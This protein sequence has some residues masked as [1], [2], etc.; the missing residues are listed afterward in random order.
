MEHVR[1][2]PHPVERVWRAI[3]EPGPVAAWFGPVDFDLRVGGN[4]RFGPADAPW[5]TSAITRLEPPTLIEFAGAK[6]TPSAGFIR[7]ELTPVDDGCRMVFTQRFEPQ[8]HFEAVLGD[9]GGDLP[10]G[11]G[12]PW[13]PGFVGG[14]HDFLDRLGRTL[15]GAAVT[16]PST[17]LF[18]RLADHAID[19]MVAERNMSAELATQTMEMFHSAER[20]NELNEIYR[21]HI[22]IAIPAE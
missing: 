7:Y 15:D 20:W 1:V 11:P 3:T 12:T 13:M 9:L 8:E 21:E 6:P 18:A 16:E 17:S 19:R 2:F 14:W 10:A 22:R 4:A 5:W